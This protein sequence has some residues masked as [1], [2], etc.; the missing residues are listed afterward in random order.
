MPE[1]SI[2]DCIS[3]DKYQ[4]SLVS[5]KSA[6]AIKIDFELYFSAVR[7]NEEIH[8]AIFEAMSGKM[9]LKD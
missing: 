1:L 4:A 2:P 6:Q 9:L 5:T 3:Q 8:E 7:E